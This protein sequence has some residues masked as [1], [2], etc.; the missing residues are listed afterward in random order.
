MAVLSKIR[1]RSLLVIAVVG[2][3]LFAFVLMDLLGS[4]SFGDSGRYVGSI[5]GKD[6]SAEEF[7][8]KV[9]NQQ[10]QNRGASALMIA[11][12]IWSQE[13]KNTLYEEQFEKL[14]LSAGQA[15]IKGVMEQTG[16]TMILDQ[17]GRFSQDKY[18]QYVEMV[19]AQYPAQWRLIIEDY[20]TNLANFAKEQAY[21]TLVKA[22]I[23]TTGF[24]GKMLYERENNKVNF[25]YVVLPY[26]TI[27]DGEVPVTDAEIVA[28]MSKRKNQYKADDSRDFEYV[29]IESKASDQ[30]I[31][32]IEENLASLLEPRT[33]Y[34]EAIKANETLPGF[35]EAENV[36]EFVNANSDIPFD[37]K[38]IFGK[39][40]PSMTEPTVG[41][42]TSLYKENDY[43]KISRI[44]D[45]KSVADSVK[46]SHII[47]PY[48]GSMAATPEAVS[49]EEAK[50]Q[51]DSIFNLVRNNEAKFREIADEINTD[52]TKGNGGEIGWVMYSQITYEGF[53]QDFAEFIFF[54]PQGSIEVVDTKFG[55]HIIK[56]DET[57]SRENA[58]KVATIA[59]QIEPSNTTNDQV[60]SFSQ[61]IEMEAQSKSLEEIAREHN[62]NLV[63]V[64]GITAIEENIIGIG[65]Q[66]NIVQ[67]AFG[68]DARKESVRRFDI[69]QGHVIAKM[70][71]INTNG[72]QSIEK[73]RPTVEPLV[74]NEKKAALIKEKIQ[75]GATLEE[76][77]QAN[78]ETVK[79]ATGISLS[80]P[81]LQG[82]GQEPKVVGK[83]LA[84]AP[85]E[86][87]APIEGKSGVYVIRTQ[88]VVKAQELPNYTTQ[89]NRLKTQSQGAVEGRILTSLTQK[90]DIKDKRI[91]LGF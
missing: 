29:L 41:T 23:N 70:K 47:I 66:R 21:N 17:M 40:L 83:A 7:R 89:S 31:K 4:G 63:P 18:N 25:D 71:N 24:D 11:N 44:L 76:I 27:N 42:V 15:Q 20:E 10:E 35:G 30:D 39:N 87:S 68:R 14:G 13:V 82:L 50:T 91:D 56:I 3:A 5:N 73:A 60:Y 32:E 48:Q 62:L 85:G 59:R 16:N 90:A 19:K 46:S 84:M 88:A 6:I 49:K 78:N 45:S 79:S 28:Y 65:A 58:Y 26:A 67:W 2:L 55:Y 9:A 51:A 43:I 57:G 80:N 1:Q 33:V 36:E 64:N 61:Q 12:N 53:D 86:I 52:G 81:T 22:G 72:L 54:N 8:F 69:S 77:A 37:E 34:N 75:S 38:Y 74:R